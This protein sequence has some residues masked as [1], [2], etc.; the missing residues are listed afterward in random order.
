MSGPPATLLS[1]LDNWNV[2]IDC[3]GIHNRYLVPFTTPSPHYHE[4]SKLSGEM[5]FFASLAGVDPADYDRRPRELRL[6]I[7]RAKRVKR[8]KRVKQDDVIYPYHKM[9]DDRLTDDYHHMRR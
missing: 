9:N 7:Q 6:A 5:L 8:V 1:W 2:Q 4:P 3:F